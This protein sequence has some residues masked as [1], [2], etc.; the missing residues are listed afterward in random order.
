MRVTRGKWLSAS[1]ALLVALFGATPIARAAEP[2]PVPYLFTANVAGDSA[3]APSKPGGKAKAGKARKFK[4]I[5]VLAELP[6]EPIRF[7]ARLV[8]LG[9]PPPLVAKP[10]VSAPPVYRVPLPAEN[11]VQTAAPPVV[12]STDP[13]KVSASIE[14]VVSVEGAAQLNCPAP[15]VDST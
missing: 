4:L 15:S 2:Y 5:T 9:A 7:E 3:E 13:I 12:V 8:S 6:A 10:A 1:A 14:P 11:P